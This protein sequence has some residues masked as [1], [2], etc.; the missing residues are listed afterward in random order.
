MFSHRNLIAF[1]TALANMLGAAAVV[2]YYLLTDASYDL[3]YMPHFVFPAGMFL[4]A[5]GTILG[6]RYG[7]PINRFLDL[8][9]T[10]QEAHPE[11]DKYLSRAVNT[12]LSAAVISMAMWCLAGPL[13]GV[14]GPILAGRFDP[15]EALETLFGITMVGGPVTTITVFLFIEAVWRREL[16]QILKGRDISSLSQAV[17]IPVRARLAP[18]MLAVSLTPLFIMAGASIKESMTLAQAAGIQLDVTPVVKTVAFVAAVGAANAV[19]V[20]LFLAH[21]VSQPLRSLTAGMAKAAEADFS[22]RVAPTSNDEIGE[23]AEGYN[24]MLTGLA[25]REKLKTAFGRYMDP[26]V[27]AEVLDRGVDLEGEMKEVTVL[28]SDLRDFT[29]FTESRH[30]KEVLAKLNA[31]FSAMTR[32]IQK[33]KGVVLQYVGD[34]IYAVFGAPLPNASHADNALAAAREMRLALA[35]L[36]RAWSAA[37]EVSLEHGVG[38]HSGD[39]LA[40]HVGSE[41]R[42]S[43]ALVGDTINTTARVCELCKIY[44]VDL[45]VTDQTANL[46]TDRSGLEEVERVTVR[47]RRDDVVIH[48]A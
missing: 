19:I 37:G 8:P 1:L 17:K 36:N 10:E 39:A 23:L 31:Y 16:P 48:R 11:R 44:G 45:L 22:A 4:I 35:E 30:P 20:S 15:A 27:A 13:F 40:G 7:R 41:N 18:I 14:V 25:E 47:G 43:Y 42:L 33:H 2:T 21:S 46:L 32:V 29:G 28:F 38:V 6:Q 26:D 24:R 5:A 12:P 34:E 9:M 3:I